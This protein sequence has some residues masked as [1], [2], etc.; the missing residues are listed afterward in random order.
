[1]PYAL[2]YTHT[3]VLLSFNSTIFLTMNFVTISLL[4][5]VSDQKLNFDQYSTIFL[6]LEPTSNKTPPMM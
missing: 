1:M 2:R 4:L 5:G 3:T 6:R